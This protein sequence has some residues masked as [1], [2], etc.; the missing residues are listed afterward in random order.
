MIRG[1]NLKTFS[2]PPGIVLLVIFLQLL[3]QG[4]EDYEVQ[5]EKICNGSLIF[6]HF[7]PPYYYEK[8]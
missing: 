2:A 8:D 4:L 5:I 1:H 7:I 3:I 6:Y